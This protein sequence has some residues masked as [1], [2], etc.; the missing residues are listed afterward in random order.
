MILCPLGT[1]RL[2]AE[3]IRD[4]LTQTWHWS[5][6]N[7]GVRI[8]YIFFSLISMIILLDLSVFLYTVRFR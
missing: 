1:I 5:R 4:D 8:T 6:Q 3:D 7:P 2:P